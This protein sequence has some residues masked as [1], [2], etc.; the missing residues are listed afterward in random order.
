MSA[1]QSAF[2]IRITSPLGILFESGA[3]VRADIVTDKG[4]TSILAKHQPSIMVVNAGNIVCE[5][6][7][8]ETFECHIEN[9]TCIVEPEQNVNLDSYTR[10]RIVTM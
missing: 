10:V 2:N 7:S 5:L 3:V 8:G 1:H 9:G 6:S 4:P